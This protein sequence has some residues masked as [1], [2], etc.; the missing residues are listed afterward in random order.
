MKVKLFP[1][2]FQEKKKSSQSDESRRPS[3]VSDVGCPPSRSS[4]INPRRMQWWHC[5]LRYSSA[6]PILHC[7]TLAT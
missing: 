4:C 5:T 6:W 7:P 1:P 3:S 2:N